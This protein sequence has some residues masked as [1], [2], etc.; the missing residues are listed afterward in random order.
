MTRHHFECKNPTEGNM[1]PKQKWFNMTQH[2]LGK[3]FM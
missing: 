3:T 2:V 1:I